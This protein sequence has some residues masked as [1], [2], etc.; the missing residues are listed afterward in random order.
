MLCQS[1]QV[2]VGSQLLQHMPFSLQLLRA[3]QAVHVHMPYAVHNIKRVEA[4]EQ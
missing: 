4:A 3:W 2:R 1:Q